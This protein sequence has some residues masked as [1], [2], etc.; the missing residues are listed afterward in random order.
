M[1]HSIG[2]V[3]V[4]QVAYVYETV[5]PCNADGSIPTGTLGWLWGMV[6]AVLMVFIQR[7]SRS[8]AASNELCGIPL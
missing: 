7:P 4:Q 8:T 5:S 3:R 2:F 1:Q 6:T